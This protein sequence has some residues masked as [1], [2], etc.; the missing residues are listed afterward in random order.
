[1]VIATAISVDW[2]RSTSTDT[3]RQDP[4]HPLV[5]RW[6]KITLEKVERL[7]LDFFPNYYLPH[8]VC[9]RKTARR[10]NCVLFLTQAQKQPQVSLWKNAYLLVPRFKK[11][12]WTFCSGFNSS[13]LPCQPTLQRFIR[14]WNLR[15]RKQ[16]LAAI[17]LLVECA[18][19]ERVSPKLNDQ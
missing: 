16:F 5:W 8:Y 2:S 4:N 19:L 6:D 3:S 1:M 11:T 14:K 9:W 7:E 15:C 10:Q 12:S 17:R 18:S 13:N